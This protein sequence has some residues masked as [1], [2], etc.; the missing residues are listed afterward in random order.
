[1]LNHL[2]NASNIAYTEN[3]AR[4]YRSTGSSCLDLFASCGALRGAS[5]KEII[6]KFIRAYAEDSDLAMR[7]LFYARDVRGGLGERRFFKTCLHYLANNEPSSVIRNMRYIPEYGRYDDLL[8][9]IGTK[10]ES[11]AVTMIKAQLKSDEE[12]M[13]DGGEV[14]LLAKWLPS[15]N[16]S[17]TD[18]RAMAKK[19]CALLGMKESEYRKK[20]SALR[21]HI[22]IIEDGLRRGDYS[23]NYE[24]VPAKAMLRYR[25][26]FLRNDF[27]RYRRYLDMVN[28]GKAKMNASTV[29]PYEIVMAAFREH[30]LYKIQALDSQWRALPDYTDSRNAIAVVDGSGS[31]YWRYSEVAPIIEAVSLGM[32]FAERNTGAFANH[33][34]TFSETPQLVEIKGYNIK[35]RAEYCMSYN[36]V[37]NTDICA[38]FRLILDTAIKNEL[39]QSELP[40]LIYILS[41]MEFDCGAICDDSLFHEIKAMY[42]THGYKLPQIVYW[43]LCAQNEQYPI[44]MNE[45]GVVLVSGSSPSVF[46]AKMNDETDPYSMMMSVLESERYRGIS[47]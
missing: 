30:D 38:V 21:A 18:T 16:T 41:D 14:S 2:K 4:A 45:K 6:L 26:A 47:A 44:T 17:S 8:C 3:G 20:L 35:K 31:M 42:E 32:Y 43:N 10:C 37:A 19:L 39:P 15:V 22:G 5:V 25:A 46:S 36:E 13:R 34:I 33:F 1:M 9:L 23:F 28:Q 12:T 29:Y 27:R 40:E 11:N 24:N 7:I